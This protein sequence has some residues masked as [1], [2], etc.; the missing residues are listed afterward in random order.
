M[1][2]AITANF[3]TDPFQDQSPVAIGFQRG[4]AF[5]ERELSPLF[6]GPEVFRNDAVRAEHDHKTLLAR[7]LIGKSKAGKIQNERHRRS[8]QTQIPQKLTP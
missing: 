4:E 2:V 3:V 6:V 7:L 5:L 1:I 8:A